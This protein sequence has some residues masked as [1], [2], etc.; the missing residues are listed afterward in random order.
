MEPGWDPVDFSWSDSL[1]LQK[2]VTWVCPHDLP[3][4]IAQ[5]QR[6][7]LEAGVFQTEHPVVLLSFQGCLVPIT[8]HLYCLVCFR[9]SPPAACT[10]PA[11]SQ[12][13]PLP[14]L[15][16]T[17]SRELSKS[18]LRSRPSRSSQALTVHLAQE[19]PSLFLTWTF[20]RFCGLYVPPPPSPPS[21]QV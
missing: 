21:F 19:M 1:C 3:F 16:R 18:L 12:L 5:F 15:S 4:Q 14:A 7:F 6:P 9:P 11:A 13:V 8:S 2:L 10:V 20:N 17:T